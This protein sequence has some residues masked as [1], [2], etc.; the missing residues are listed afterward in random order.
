MNNTNKLLGIKTEIK[1]LQAKLR[2]WSYYYYVKNQPLVSDAV[3]DYFYQKLL[4]Y[5]KKYP[6]LITKDSITQ[7]VGFKPSKKFQPIRHQNRMLSL[8]NAFNLADLEKFDLRIRKLIGNNFTYHCELKIDGLPVNLVFKNH[9]F[10]SC[11]TRGDGEV[12][13]NVTENFLSIANFATIFGK[14]FPLSTF[15]ISGEVFIS[16][17]HFQ[18]LNQQIKHQIQQQFINDKAILNAL[19]PK[20]QQLFPTIKWQ[21]LPTQ[22]NEL[23]FTWNQ[24]PNYYFTFAIDFASKLS[25]INLKTKITNFFQSHRTFYKKFTWLSIN[26][27]TFHLKFTQTLS[28]RFFLNARNAASGS[29]RQLDSQ[30]TKSRNLAIAFF[31]FKTEN[32][33]LMPL[34]QANS[35]N[36]IETKLKLPIIP[37]RKHCAN[38]QAVWKWIQTIKSK[39]TTLPLEIDGIVIKINELN[40]TKQLG[41]TVKFPRFAIAYKFPDQTAES[42]LLAIETTVG[43]T[44]KLS[45]V[46]LLKPT[47]LLGSF[48]QRATLHNASFI[49]KLELRISDFVKFKKSGGIIPKII[50]VNLSKRSHKANIWTPPVVCPFC[51]NKLITFMNEVDQYCVN[52]HCP[53][54]IIRRM[55]HFVA[56]YAYN[57][58]GLSSQTLKHLYQL[59]LIRDGADLFGL[60]NQKPRLESMIKNKV[61]LNFQNRALNNLLTAIQ[62]AKNQPLSRLLVAL[63]IRHLGF[64][65]ARLL[66]NHFHNLQNIID[67]KQTDWLKLAGIGPKLYD[68]WIKFSQNP[69]NQIVLTKLINFGVNTNAIISQSIDPF[70]NQKRVVITGTFPI[71]RLK[72]QVK[73][74]SLGAKVSS[75]IS[76]R[77]DY[78]L[79][80]T[81][82]GQKY[83]QARQKKIPCLN[84]ND[85]E[86]ILKS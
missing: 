70:W 74:E 77:T 14:K 26:E 58:K 64:K 42:Q 56:R 28:H 43:R 36:Y 53:E 10:Q 44:G 84:A 33:K 11:A 41:S 29:L 27:S 76:D 18:I 20:L 21:L 38:L 72:I 61:L 31:S 60:I 73:L 80:G 47:F 2:R 39:I 66:A 8:D 54:I 5:E 51:H 81:N 67:A 59:K 68:S 6:T 13:E 24:N 71:S 78:L 45:F 62:A 19:I 32:Q 7:K 30:I 12:G 55:E 40:Y 4:Y 83:F 49:Q 9:F 48:V 82:P 15:E 35:L 25:I 22:L 86:K 69:Q 34:T 17:S 57:I 85:I 65:S 1:A 3:Y 52:W 50:A 16:K 63:G 23:D 75:Q 37:Y 79:V 46:A